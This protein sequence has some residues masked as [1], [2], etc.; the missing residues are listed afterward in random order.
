[1]PWSRILERTAVQRRRNSAVETALTARSWGAFVMCRDAA[2]STRNDIE[3]GISAPRKIVP[4]VVAHDA[5]GLIEVDVA[6]AADQ[7]CDHHPLG[8]PQRVVRWERLLAEH[9]QGRACQAL[10]MQ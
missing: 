2:S 5:V 9:V 1:M 10:S 4:Q 6:H 8:V 3:H 7:R